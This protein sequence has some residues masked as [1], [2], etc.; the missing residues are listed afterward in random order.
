MGTK[1]YRG[2]ISGLIYILLLILFGACTSLVTDGK[3]VS[4]DGMSSFPVEITDQA[5]RVIKIDIVPDR[6][7]SLAPS[8][9]EILYALE[10]EDKVVGV[11]EYCDYPEAAKKN[12]K[13]G[14]FS[15]VDIEKVVELEPDLV[16]AANIHMGEVVTALENLGL[17]VF[18]IDPGTVGEVLEAIEMVGRFTGK[19][20]EASWMTIEMES[21]IKVVT[22]KTMAIPK[23]QRP[24]VFYIVWHDP[25]M[26]AGSVTLI[27]ELISAAGGVS[28]VENLTEEF[29]NIGL[30]TV[31][32]A[33]PQI[34][35][36]GGGH[37]SGEDLPFIFALNEP[38]LAKIEAR[39]NDRVYEIDSDLTSR[40]G[41]RIVDGLEMMAEFIHPE[42]FKDGVHGS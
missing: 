20:E 17:T 15:T 41:M 31:I 28:I 29:P 38:R 9:T 10:L 22:D 27:Q 13:V 11:T 35:I 6:I 42:L 1:L 12:M 3:R 7:I 24:S 21:R 18:I 8:I 26:T 37:G 5:G 34:V 36:V 19:K 30:E 32:M 16:L 4:S 23:A 2:V 33:N 14:G 39:L 40:P 25:L